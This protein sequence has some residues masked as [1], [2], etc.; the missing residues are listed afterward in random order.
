MAETKNLGT[1]MAL[2]IG[3][4]AP[5]NTNLIWLDTSL[6]IPL[7]KAYNPTTS[8][9]EPFTYLTLIDNSTIKKDGDGK[10]YVDVTTIPALQVADGSIT[11]IKL[12]N[13][14]SGS[15]FYRKSVGTGIPEVQELAT[16]KVDL[17]LTGTNS[18]DQDLSG[19]AL[20]TI[21]INGKSLETNR[22]LT[23]EDI[24]SP[25]GSGTSTGENTGDET[26]QTILQKLELTVLSGENTGDETYDSIIELFGLEDNE[27]TFTLI[28]TTELSRLQLIG[29]SYLI[30]LPSNTTVAGR[31]VGLVEGTDYPTGWAIAVGSSEY[32]LLI[33]HSLSKRV[34]NI[35]IFSV[36][37]GQE[38]LL[39]PFNNAY[40]GILLPNLNSILIEALTDIQTDIK[41]V[42]TFA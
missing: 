35:N 28:S 17:G 23:P 15:V 13:V 40:T 16:L 8:N 20:K 31:I 19:L 1:I 39:R 11:L 9:W 34:A 27:E 25:E 26:N 4:T 32:D 24:G 2:W 6:A 18:G 22:T 21:T 29:S 37:E 36:S 10:L 14:A 3:T 33:T 12:A 41:I 5:T 30:S 42:I 38:R 7:H